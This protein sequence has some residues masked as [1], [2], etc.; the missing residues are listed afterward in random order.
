MLQEK[1]HIF[2][3][4]GRI[5]LLTNKNGGKL[6]NTMVLNKNKN[7]NTRGTIKDLFVHLLTCSIK[8]EHDSFPGSKNVNCLKS[9]SHIFTNSGESLSYKVQ[10]YII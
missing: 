8:F 5:S 3:L 4:D 10:T 2:I 7:L 1:L 6:Q 9:E